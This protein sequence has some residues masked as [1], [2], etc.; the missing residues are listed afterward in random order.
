VEPRLQ[1]AVEVPMTWA[2]PYRGNLT[3]LGER[4]ILVVN[5]GS[6]AYGTDT[7]ASDA[8]VRGIAIPP[9][10]YF[11]GFAQGFKQ[12]ESRDPDLVVF[13]VRKFFRL[14]AECN[15][16]VLETLWTD[17]GDLRLSTP[18]GERLLA[19][20]SLFLSKRVRWTYSGYAMSQL[21]RIRTHHR[22]LRSP[23]SHRPTREEFGLGNST[24]IPGDQLAAARSMVAKRLEE[25]RMDDLDDL[26]PAHKIAVRA[27]MEER[28][29]EILK[30]SWDEERGW[31]TAARS[32]GF[33]DNFVYLLAQEKGYRAR[34]AEWDQ[35]QTWVESRNPARAELE[36]K[37]GYDTKH[38]Y[39]LVRLMRMCRE[40]LTTGQLLVRRPDREELLAIRNGAW[41]I[42]RLVEWAERQDAEMGAVAEASALPRSADREALDRL[43][44][45]LVEESFR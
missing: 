31:S 15:P 12:A 35:Y 7:P 29:A 27:A 23:P 4:T 5:A 28:L 17:A 36:A 22:W 25:W 33:S 3:W 32:L 2:L 11:H 41:T 44:V 19:G 18:I 21:K 13:G 14:A 10:S 16:N 40:I 34:K 9:A 24:P 6:R 45:E 43:C 8:D 42:D 20:R 37:W 38:G 1:A 39:H 30:W 26:E